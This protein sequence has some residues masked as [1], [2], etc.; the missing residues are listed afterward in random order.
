MNK[1]K[2]GRSRLSNQLIVHF[3]NQ[4]LETIAFEVEETFFLGI[5]FFD[6]HLKN[7]EMTLHLLSSSNFLVEQSKNR[8][9]DVV[10]FGRRNS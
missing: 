9:T 2:N 4:S 3:H 10:N 8:R 7:R 5:S 1:A 6:I